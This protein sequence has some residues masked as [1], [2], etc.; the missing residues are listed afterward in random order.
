[1][2]EGPEYK[3]SKANLFMLTHQLAGNLSLG[4]Q[5]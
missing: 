4:F 1:M 3:P 2:E 5:Q